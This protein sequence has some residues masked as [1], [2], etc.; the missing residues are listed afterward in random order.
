MRTLT[1]IGPLDLACHC[2][3]CSQGLPHLERRLNAGTTIVETCETA[4][5][6][7]RRLELESRSHPPYRWSLGELQEQVRRHYRRFGITEA[8]VR[9]SGEGVEVLFGC[10]LSTWYRSPEECLRQVERFGSAVL[11]ADAPA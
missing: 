8:N 4:N 9:W 10:G 5:E 11:I 2:P 1:D 7:R 6:R 3:R